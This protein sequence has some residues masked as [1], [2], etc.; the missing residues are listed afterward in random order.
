MHC[1]HTVHT[2]YD[3]L[4]DIFKWLAKNNPRPPTATCKTPHLRVFVFSNYGD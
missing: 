1:I 3:R 2:L 4:I